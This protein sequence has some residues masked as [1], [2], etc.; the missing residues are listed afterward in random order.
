MKKSPTSATLNLTVNAGVPVM[1]REIEYQNGDRISF[2]VA[3]P[4]SSNATLPELHKQSVARVIQLLQE[5][6]APK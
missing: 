1:S 6:I 2:S 5:W 3:L 4:D